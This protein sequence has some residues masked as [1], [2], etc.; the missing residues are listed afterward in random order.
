[1]IDAGATVNNTRQS[2]TSLGLLIIVKHLFTDHCST[3]SEPPAEILAHGYY[4]SP[5]LRWAIAKNVF[6]V[7]S[8][9][10]SGKDGA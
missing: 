1:M 2:H 6:S 4:D 3:A 10:N 5:T 8:P 7:C 9:R